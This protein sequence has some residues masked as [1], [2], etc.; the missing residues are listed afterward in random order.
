[1][2]YYLSLL[3]ELFQV[4]I[5]KGESRQQLIQFNDLLLSCKSLQLDTLLHDA[6]IELNLLSWLVRR[7]Y[8]FV[9]GLD[10]HILEI[11]CLYVMIV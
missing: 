10:I 5:R 6:R 7:L 2:G 8:N 4:L 9:Q 3:C 1:M 11:I